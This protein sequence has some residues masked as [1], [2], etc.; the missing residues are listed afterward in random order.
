MGRQ[1]GWLRDS[2]SRAS[3]V[4][5]GLP[6][7]TLA[8][9]TPF[10]HVHPEPPMK[11]LPAFATFVSVFVA[12]VLLHF[13]A[14]AQQADLA[15]L[16][17]VYEESKAEL[18][19]PVTDFQALYAGNLEKLLAEATSAGDL[20]Q[21]LAVKAELEGFRT[22]ETP[23]AEERHARLKQLQGVYR[24]TLPQRLAQANEALAPLA[25]SYRAKLEELQVALTRQEKIAEALQVKAALEALEA[26][27]KELAEAAT[28]QEAPLN[29]SVASVPGTRFTGGKL[30]AIGRMGGITGREID[31][32]PAEGIDDFIDVTGNSRMWTALRKNGTVV[33]WR[34]DGGAFTRPGI[35]RLATG[36]SGA[37]WGISTEGRLTELTSGDVHELPG[38]VAHAAI[39][40]V[41]SIALLEDGTVHVWGNLYKGPAANRTPMPQPPAEAMRDGVAIAASRYG[42]YVLKKNGDLMGWRHSGHVYKSFPRELRGATRLWAN[43]FTVFVEVRGRTVYR[44]PVDGLEREGVTQMSRSLADIRVGDNATVML[45]DD[46][47]KFPRGD[48]QWSD[49]HGEGDALARLDGGSL[50]SVY[51]ERSQNRPVVSYLLWLAP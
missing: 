50:P 26:G 42:A 45:E 11:P 9:L 23:E 36:R 21:V 40:D 29:L 46:R 12:A 30:H 5:A 8:D 1:Q 13:P 32:G 41:H 19:K 27:E 18:L 25:A 38:P 7:S 28:K 16:T 22:G 35:K 48:G 6:L 33:G 47:W 3:A 43:A 17:Q 31:L 51:Q 24:Q 14:A 4:H 44:F 20:E 37:S 49:V 2:G 15:T 10:R 39:E 34:L